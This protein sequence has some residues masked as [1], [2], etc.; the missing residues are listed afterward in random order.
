VCINLFKIVSVSVCVVLFCSESL[1]LEVKII[2]SSVQFRFSPPG[3][4]V[5]LCPWW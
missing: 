1:Y 4:E 2:F 5:K 3:Y